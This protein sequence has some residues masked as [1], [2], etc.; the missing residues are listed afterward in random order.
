MSNSGEQ[1]ARMRATSFADP[2][3]SS[4]SSS[5]GGVR[6]FRKS[7]CEELDITSF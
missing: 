5:V 4:K 6:T 2:N 7:I 1:P 3:A